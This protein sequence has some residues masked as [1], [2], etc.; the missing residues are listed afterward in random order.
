MNT[1]LLTILMSLS[2]LVSHTY[3]TF[4][5]AEPILDPVNCNSVV[6]DNMRVE[7][8]KQQDSL[9][10]DMFS[11]LSSPCICLLEMDSGTMI[12]GRNE[13]ERRSPASI[14]KI[15]TLILAMDQVKGG[16]ISL[17]DEVVVSEYAASM[18][19]SQ[20]FL[21][22]GEKQSLD[23]LLKCIAV[24]SA[25]DA[26]VAVAE[27]IAGTE[28]NFVRMMNEKAE[29]MGLLNTHFVDCCGLSD[30]DEHYTSA[31]DVACMAKYLMMNHPEIEK[32]TQIWS[33]NIVHHTRRG[34]SIFTL[35]STNK[36]LRQSDFVTG[37]K[38]GSTAKAKYCFCATAEKENERMVAVVLGCDNPKLRFSEA[39][40]LLQYGFSV[41][42]RYEDDNQETLP[43]ASVKLGMDNLVSVTYERPFS[44]VTFGEKREELRKE[45]EKGESLIAPIYKG[46]VV[47]KVL[48]FQGDH[49]VGE[50]NIVATKT[51]EKR[52]VRFCFRKLFDEFLL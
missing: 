26:S 34:D 45:I 29:S 23:T 32:Y 31:M 11:N 15:M 41:T 36:L 44:Y 4:F 6:E 39:K 7:E 51:V 9:K 25:N 50:V 21:E 22:A 2:L 19:G 43:D 3:D 52:N 37:L 48:Y 18:G 40:E 17:E 14:T 27:H 33:E 49:M 13:S 12:Y 20:V 1:I 8:G 24:S 38:T 35:N 16:G 46:D 5:L 10:N 42:E 30:C 28:E 47:G